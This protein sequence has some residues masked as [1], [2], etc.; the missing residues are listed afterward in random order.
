MWLAVWAFVILQ[1]IGRVYEGGELVFA[2][3]F[4]TAPPVFLCTGGALILVGAKRCKLAWISALIYIA[5]FLVSVL[6]V[7][8][9]ALF[10]SPK[11]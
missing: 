3:L 5:P 8:A 11:T 9:A 2:A 4:L 10:Q 6:G 1:I 7:A